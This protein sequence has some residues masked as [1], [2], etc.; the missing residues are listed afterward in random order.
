MDT[1]DFITIN[2]A[3]VLGILFL[4]V[5]LHRNAEMDKAMKKS[6]YILIFLEIAEMVVY[7]AELVT[8][9]FAHFSIWRTVFSVV[10][11]SIRPFLMC[12]ILRIS[13]RDH[14]SP[15][16]K[17]R[18]ALPTL[19]DIAI[20]STALFTDFWFGYTIGRAHV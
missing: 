5:F 17:F 19:R 1:F 7:S 6:F 2:F 8:A 16:R 3:T 11:Y 12:M 4:C 20:I 15:T 10:G 18:L 13:L 9:S 14:L